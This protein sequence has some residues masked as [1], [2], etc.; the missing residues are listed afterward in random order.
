MSLAPA[1]STTLSPA[2][3]FIFAYSFL[4]FSCL[5]YFIFSPLLYSLFSFL[6]ILFSPITFS[7]LLILLRVLI[8]CISTLLINC[9]LQISSLD[10]M[11]IR[12]YARQH[13]H[14]KENR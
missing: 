13:Q 9:K 3:H 7:I 10:I 12:S 5:S 14:R 6:S 8:V 1:F 4:F 2:I 11:T